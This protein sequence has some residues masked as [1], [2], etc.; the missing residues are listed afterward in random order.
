MSNINFEET[1]K[2]LNSV[3]KN[4]PIYTSNAQIDGMSILK[5]DTL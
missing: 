1:K 4:D 5:F 2:N 3:G